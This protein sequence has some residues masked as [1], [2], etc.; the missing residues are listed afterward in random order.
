MFELK[1]LLVSF[2]LIVT[3]PTISSPVAQVQAF[4][5]AIG[6]SNVHGGG[7]AVGSVSTPEGTTFQASQG[8][9]TVSG[10]NVPNGGIAVG[11]AS[12]PDGTIS[13]AAQGEAMLSG[14]NV[15]N[16]GL[17]VVGSVPSPDGTIVQAA[18]PQ[19]VDST[20][21]SGDIG[22][23]LFYIEEEMGTSYL[24]SGYVNSLL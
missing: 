9:Q 22:S 14:S 15:P 17:V 1:V 6:G 4:G 3:K 5:G 12:A 10:S 23:Y 24:I 18:P 16:N 19:S 13:H 11:G 8:G 21:P 2:L 20:V 7:I